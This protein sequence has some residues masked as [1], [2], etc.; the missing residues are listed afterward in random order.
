MLACAGTARNSESEYSRENV[1]FMVS[2]PALSFQ[3]LTLGVNGNALSCR[4]AC[5]STEKEKAG[6]VVP[7]FST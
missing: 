1:F 6:D 2:F 3:I 4:E 7:G 5:G